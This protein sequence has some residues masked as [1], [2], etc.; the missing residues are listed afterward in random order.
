MAV[1]IRYDDNPG[2]IM[3]VNVS[4]NGG[5]GGGVNRYVVSCGGTY[6]LVVLRM[7]EMMMMIMVII[8]YVTVITMNA[9]TV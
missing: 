1:V 8:V 2:N 4:C 3:L 7:T 9:K 6:D 5:G